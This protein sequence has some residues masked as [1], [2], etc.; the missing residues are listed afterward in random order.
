[1]H[2][3]KCNSIFGTLYWKQSVMT[4]KWLNLTAPLCPQG[5]ACRHDIAS[6]SYFLRLLGLQNFAK[7]SENKKREHHVLM[8]THFFLPPP[9]SSPVLASHEITF[10]SMTT[11]LPSITEMTFLI[12]D[13][14]LIWHDL[15]HTLPEI[16]F[17][18]PIWPSA[19]RTPP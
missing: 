13:Q 8:T 16:T 2:A 5:L 3:E 11:P 19:W 17:G 1:M 10:P 12:V 7:N 6:F 18:V 14:Y 9:F 4:I 15:E